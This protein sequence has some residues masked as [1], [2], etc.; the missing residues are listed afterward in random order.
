M[1]EVRGR[2]TEVWKDRPRRITELLELSPARAYQEFIAE[3]DR[4][5]TFGRFL[6]S[7]TAGAAWLSAEG[8]E[9]GDRVMILM[10]NSAEVLL[11]VWAL[12]RLGAV[13]VPANPSWTDPELADVVERLHP[14]AFVTDRAL[15]PAIGRPVVFSSS[16]VG[17]WWSSPPAAIDFR[18]VD[19][20]DDVALILFTAG[21]TGFSKGVLLSHRNLLATQQTVHLMRDNW[22]PT[23]PEGGNA[24]TLITMP[25]FHLGGLTASVTALLDGDRIVLPGGRFD[26]LRTLELIESERV[27]AWLGAPTMYSRLFDHPEFGRF[28]LSTLTTPTTGSTMVPPQLISA[29]AKILPGAAT[30]IGV[31]YGMTEMAFLTQVSGAEIEERPG[32]VGRPIPNVRVK[33]HHPDEN[34]D[35]ELLARSAALMVGYLDGDEPIDSEGWYH[36]GDV[37]RIDDDGYIY[38]TGRIKDMVIRGGENVA[39]PHVENVLVDH[40]DVIEA[41]VFG[42]EDRDFGEAVAAAVYI[43]DGSNLDERALTDFAGRHLARFEVPTRWMLFSGPLPTLPTGSWTRSCCAPSSCVA[44]RPEPASGG[45]RQVSPG[46]AGGG[47]DRG[48]DR[49]GRRDGRGVGRGRRRPGAHGPPPRPARADSRAGAADRPAGRGGGRGCQPPRGV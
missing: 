23:T 40:P 45:T 2:P 12:W 10:Y 18:P 6:D 41:A 34:G 35:G 22:P 9:P 4:R 27:T 28:D 7:T 8:I 11:S 26:P 25:L 36:T 38:I 31:G 16:Q 24:V 33:I 42:V 32:T 3:K 1:E 13:P 37:A 48:I 43:R 15:A 17:A 19:D 20:E 46:R 5:Y 29:A 14:R 47:R 30:G 44:S 49:V 39:T 21:S